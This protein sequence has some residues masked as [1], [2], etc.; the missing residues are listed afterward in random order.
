MFIWIRQSF[1]EEDNWL[2]FCVRVMVL[3][4][5]EFNVLKKKIIDTNI[6]PPFWAEWLFLPSYVS[7]SFVLAC[8]FY[9]YYFFPAWLYWNIN[10]SFSLQMRWGGVNS[11]QKPIFHL[12]DIVNSHVG[13]FYALKDSAIMMLWLLWD[14]FTINFS[15][16]F[17]SIVLLLGQFL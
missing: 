6:F 8:F 2:I 17:F 1:T 10:H 16:T 15:I 9:F 4:F 7:L 3:A 13:P 11:T 14:S 5:E 12:L